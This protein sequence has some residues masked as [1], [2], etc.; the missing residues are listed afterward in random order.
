[1]RINDKEEYNKIKDT[2]NMENLKK[3]RLEK[4]FGIIK[5]ASLSNLTESTISAYECNLKTP[6]LPSL[7]SLANLFNC[8]LDFLVG[9]TNN[10][11][12]TSASQDNN[13]FILN[14]FNSLNKDNKL[15]AEAYIKGLIDGQK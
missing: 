11:N 2:I 15:K 10:P 3:I 12:I 4:G 14:N 8:S 9:R 13:D 5:T 6:S 7:I 1:M